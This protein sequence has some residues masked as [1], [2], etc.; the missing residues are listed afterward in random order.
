REHAGPVKDFLATHLK[1][2]HLDLAIGT[3]GNFETLGKLRV[4]LLHKNS[5]FSMTQKELNELVS[6]LESMSVKERI[7]FL[8]LRPDRADVLVPAARITQ[9]VMEL[10]KVELLSIPYVGLRDGILADLGSRV[11]TKV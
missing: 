10:A 7:Q 2:L 4:A 11:M 6:H 5:I 9:T 8:R 1:G 3:G